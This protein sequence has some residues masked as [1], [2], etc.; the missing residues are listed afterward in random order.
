MIMEKRMLSFAGMD[1]ELFIPEDKM[2][3]NEYRLGP[4]KTNKVADPHI[5]EFVCVDKLTA[6]EGD[7]IAKG[8]TSHIYKN[9]ERQIRYV[10]MRNSNWSEAHARVIHL[11]KKH[12]IEINEN[13]VKM[14]IPSKLILECM[15]LEHLTIQENAFVLHASFIDVNG[16]AILFTAPSETGK[17]TQADLWSKYRNAEIVNGDRAVI[18]WNGKSFFAEGIPLAGSSEYCINKSIPIKA[19]VYLDQAE[20]SRIEQLYGKGAF[21]AIW[22]GCSVNSW[23]R[24]DIEKLSSLVI[25]TIKEIPIFYLPCTPDI[26]AIEILENILYESEAIE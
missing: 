5:M 16:E 3:T 15:S 19:I 20:K 23:D 22:K 25:K 11:G 7:L 12:F 24:E 6:P 2:F 21:A 26:S 4:F 17:S 13:E 1:F 18:R 8:N 9:G 10:G 14:S